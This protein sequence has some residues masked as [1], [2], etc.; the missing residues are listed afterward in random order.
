MIW[1]VTFALICVL[2]F[3]LSLQTHIHFLFFEMT[4]IPGTYF[5]KEQ[6]EAAL[7]GNGYF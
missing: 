4:T 1:V 6:L 2:L 3:S 5:T 7:K